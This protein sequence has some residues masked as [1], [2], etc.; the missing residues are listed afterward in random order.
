VPIWVVN[1]VRRVAVAFKNR[2]E[3]P[4]PARSGSPEQAPDSPCAT[5]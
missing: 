1:T 3:P 5:R 2:F 4:R